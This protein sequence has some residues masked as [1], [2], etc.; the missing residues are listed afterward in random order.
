MV[1]TLTTSRLTMRGWREDD[2]AA[3]A[4][5]TADPEVMRFMGGAIDAGESWRQLALFAGHWVLRGYGASPS[6]SA[7]ARCARTPCAASGS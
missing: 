4:E 3:Y 1:P 6:G 7:C 2:A 5:I